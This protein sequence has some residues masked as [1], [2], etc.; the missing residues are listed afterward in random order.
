MCT[1]SN[2]DTNPTP[3]PDLYTNPHSTL[4]LI[5]SSP[6]THPV[7]G[8][9]ALMDV[10]KAVQS[11]LTIGALARAAEGACCL[12]FSLQNDCYGYGQF[13]SL[14]NLKVV[15]RKNFVSVRQKTDKALFRMCS[16]KFA[17]AEYADIIKGF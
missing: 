13:R 14:S 16:R 3:T 17:S 2:P 9:K 7:R 1:N 4:T 5:L 11:D 15:V 6:I 8:L 10:H 12:L